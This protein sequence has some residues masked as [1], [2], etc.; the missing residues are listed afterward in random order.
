MA[1]R[2]PSRSVGA[3]GSSPGLFFI[4][5]HLVA[6]SAIRQSEGSRKKSEV[7]KYTA[8]GCII[9]GDIPMWQ[10]SKEPL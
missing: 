2:H 10:R 9:G 7:P 3:G 8:T 4:Y 6:G 1:E 5:A